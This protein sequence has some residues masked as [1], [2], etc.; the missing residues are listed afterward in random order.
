[1]LPMS[2]PGQVYGTGSEKYRAGTLERGYFKPRTRAALMSAS[3]PLRCLDALEVQFRHGGNTKGGV[4][5][6]PWVLARRQ[7]IRYIN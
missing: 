3:R 7:R 1:M 6:P 2:S 5:A 4:A